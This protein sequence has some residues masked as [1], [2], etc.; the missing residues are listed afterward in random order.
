MALNLRDRYPAQTVD[1]AAYPEGK[2][3]NVTVPGDGT[4]TPWEKDIVNDFLGFF[5]GLTQ[6]AGIA[7][8]GDPDTADASD[9]I[10][11]LKRLTRRP[12]CRVLVTGTVAHNAFFNL[13]IDDQLP[14]DSFLTID[15]MNDPADPGVGL[16][17]PQGEEAT[18][19]YLVSLTGGL[20]S[21]DTTNPML[22]GLRIGL[23]TQ[24]IDINGL[25]WSASPADGVPIC[26]VQLFKAH[27]EYLTVKNV[28]GDD[29]T[30][31]ATLVVARV[32]GGQAGW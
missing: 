25:R 24:S 31:A 22:A 20:F 14:D 7:V 4:G 11:A 32:G 19:M 8:S 9:R 1:D 29:M 6:E 16:L 12:S 27:G 15:A 2:A 21:A 28:S 10:D 30:L 26:G 13:S 18:A 3:R 5:Q 23:S 17:F